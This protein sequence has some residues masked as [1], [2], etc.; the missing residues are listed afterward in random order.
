MAK[1]KVLSFPQKYGIT[2]I[3]TM[4]PAINYDRP[5]Q[6][7]K[8]AQPYTPEYRCS[9]YIRQFLIPENLQKHIDLTVRALRTN[10]DAFDA[11]AFTGMSGALIAPAVAREL[12]KT[13]IMVRKPGTTTHAAYEVEGDY[14]A[15][16]YI[17][18]D[19]F[20]HSGATEDYIV[21]SIKRDIPDAEY[22]GFVQ[23]RDLLE[24]DVV[25][26]E[27]SGKPFAFLPK[28]DFVGVEE[29]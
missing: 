26:A 6:V 9:M 17:I 14:A 29:D 20:R 21:R 10:I 12:G 24:L 7:S 13:V 27:D 16:R 1:N 19:D 3:P 11:I 15:R 18:A 22:V 25:E 4:G 23:A 28:K 5:Y 2:T 8:N